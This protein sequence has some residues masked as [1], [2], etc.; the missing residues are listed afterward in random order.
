MVTESRRHRRPGR[1]QVP[2][3]RQVQVLLVHSG[4]K[5]K[6]GLVVLVGLHRPRSIP[7][8]GA[9][10]LATTSVLQ[11]RPHPHLPKS[12]R[13]L[14]TGLLPRASQPQSHRRLIKDFT[15]QP[16]RRCPQLLLPGCCSPAGGW[17]GAGNRTR[18]QRG[19]SSLGSTK[20]GPQVPTVPATPHGH[21][22]KKQPGSFC[23][24]LTV[25]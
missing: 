6:G 23:V 11:L 24:F 17:G 16:R 19:N 7:E 13:G 15:Q 8:C 2:P 1:R 4:G 21:W 9:H 3:R 18:N 10:G 20:E 25:S 14:E 12:P 5:I 22:H